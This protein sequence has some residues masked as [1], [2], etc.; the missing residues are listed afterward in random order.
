[1]TYHKLWF[2]QTASHLKVLRPFPPFSVVQNFIREYL[3]NLIDYMDGQGL[4]L[5]DPQHWWESIYIDG[6]LELENSEGKTLRVAAGIIEQWRNANAALRLITTPAMAKLRRDSLNVSQ[7]WLFYVSS[8]KPYPESLWIDL[9]YE[10]ADTPPT[11]TGC[12][13]IEVTEPEA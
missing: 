9:L 6:I 4:D 3:P 10:Q 11:E 5:S 2:Q 13:I 8:R 12:T 1:M 7:H